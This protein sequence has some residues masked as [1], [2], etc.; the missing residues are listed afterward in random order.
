LIKY[1]LK[2]V[3]PLRTG[4][5]VAEVDIGT[6]REGRKI[7][8]VHSPGPWL[9]VELEPENYS[10]TAMLADARTQGPGW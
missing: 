7:I 9:F 10:V 6:F 2:L 3:F 8:N 4:N 5:Y 1:P